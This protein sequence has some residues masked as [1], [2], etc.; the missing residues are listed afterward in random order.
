[1]KD[2]IEALTI[3]QKYTGPEDSLTSCEHDVMYV[4]VDPGTVGEADIARLDVLGFKA[5]RR[6]Q[7]FQSYRYGS[8]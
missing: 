3:F 4:C 6:N 5:D 1:M 2:L 8:C 7:C